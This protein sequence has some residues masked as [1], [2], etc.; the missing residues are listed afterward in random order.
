MRNAIEFT[1]R[2]KG[3]SL[4]AA[5][6]AVSSVRRRKQEHRGAKKIVRDFILMKNTIDKKIYTCKN[7]CYFMNIRTSFF[8]EG[9]KKIAVK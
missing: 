4:S 1:I 2:T 9:V 3:R 8:L 7:F 6:G 5:T